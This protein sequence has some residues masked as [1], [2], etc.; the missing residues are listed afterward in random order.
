MALLFAM[1][2]FLARWL[3]PSDY[4]VYGLILA[5]V[6]L[7]TTFTVFGAPT[8]VLRFIPEYRAAKDLPRLHGV[9]GA[10]LSLPLLIGIVVAL[11]TSALIGGTSLVQPSL[12]MPFLIGIWIA[13]LLAVAEAQGGV[14]RAF[15]KPVLS[16]TPLW[17]ARP[18]FVILGAAAVGALTQM[19]TATQ[20]IGVTLAA[21]AV[22]TLSQNYALRQGS[23]WP[24]TGEVAYE[25]QKWIRVATPLW[26][27]SLALILSQ[28]ADLLI[29]GGFMSTEDVGL[30]E[31]AS[32]TALLGNMVL[33]GVN[34]LAAPTF[35]SL[36]AKDDHAGLNRTASAAA[37]LA[38][39]P[40]LP[41][42]TGLVIFGDQVLGLF[43]DSFVLVRWELAIL[44]TAQLVG[45]AVGSVGYLLNVTGHQRDTLRTLLI[46]SAVNIVLNL[47]VVPRWGIRGAAIVTAATT[48][49]WNL[50]LYALVRRRL[51]IRPSAFARSTS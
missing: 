12:R 2:V 20:A 21:V 34:F 30:Y 24:A 36:F 37:R 7:L 18:M 13:P 50:W 42:V 22:A 40:T 10:S 43:G 44:A 15:G 28:R 23:S 4:G 51:Q 38:F 16:L 49:G 33:T 35:A 32:R 1:Q 14:A 26:L 39:W 8:A 17:I 31:A 25:F 27:A 5:W 46:V 48:V 9:I 3:G 11:L 45:A 41:L 47:L 29:I 6:T 19:L